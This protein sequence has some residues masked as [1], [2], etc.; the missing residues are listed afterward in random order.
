MSSDDEDEYFHEEVSC[1]CSYDWTRA[2]YDHRR[3]VI[4][5]GA[6][7]KPWEYTDRFFPLPNAWLGVSIE[8]QEQA[9]KRIPELLTIP[10][11]K[12]FIVIDPM[13]DQ[14]D[15]VKTG[16][17]GCDCQPYENEDGEI[18]NRCSS[19]CNHYKNAIDKSKRMIDWIIV[20]GDGFA[21]AH[22][23]KRELV[24]NVKKQ[25]DDSGVPFFFRQRDMQNA[26]E[27]QTG[28]DVL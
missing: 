20:G 28:E 19:R 9:D 14:V 5:I 26:I 24:L 2:K 3:K 22:P 15:I 18:E 8:N 4:Q 21:N 17:F 23:T 1:L 12:R 25:C 7:R 13:F 6:E 16:A 27:K 11:T 10:A